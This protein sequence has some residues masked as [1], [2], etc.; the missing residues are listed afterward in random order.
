MNPAPAPT[1]GLAELYRHVWRHAQGVRARWVGAA[2]LLV[3]SQL[4]K[5][6][7]PWMAAQ[8]INTIQQGGAQALQQ[9]AWWIGGIFGVYVLSWSTHGPGRVLER[10]VGV[11]VRQSLSNDLFHRLSHAPLAWHDRH[12]SGELQHRVA[13]ASHA[14]GDFAQ[15][16]YIYLQNA[17]NLFGPLVALATLSTLTGVHAMIGYLV[18]ALVIWRFDLRLT[19]L[20]AQENHADRRYA[21]TLL[22]FLSNISTLMSQRF[23]AHAQRLLGRRLQA[24]FAPLQRNIL[25]TEFKWC[26]VDLLSVALTWSLV[27]AY[28]WHT[29]DAGGTL[30]LGSVFMVYEYAN[31]A[32]G[33]IGAMAAN[34]QNLARIRTDY[35]SCDVIREAPRAPH[36]AGMPLDDW[37]RLDVVDLRYTR[38]DGGGLSGITFQLERGDRVAIVGPSGAGKSTL[39]R[40]LA[41]LYE[42]THGH[43][44]V[45]GVAPLGMRHLGRVTTLIPQEAEVFE[46]TMKENIA[47]DQDVPDALL[48][49]V[50]R[51]SALDDVL[52]GQ[53]LRWE[54]PVVERGAN[55][56][57]GQRQRLCLA[58]GVLAA[59]HSAVVLLDEPTSALDPLTENQVLSQ[60]MAAFPDACVM[61]S[62]HRMSLL[63]H[64][65]KVLLVAE[66]RVVDMGPIAEVRARQALFRELLEHTPTSTGQSV[67]CSEAMA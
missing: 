2:S 46:A 52:A 30:L 58:R 8:A 29:R 53:P 64:F 31:R 23:Q 22:D 62:L 55:L 26:A 20:V 42:P 45:D 41:G 43:I 4:I 34:F 12:H 18:V 15:N 36:E 39:L 60:I 10:S 7:A 32:G 13:Q 44:E 37:Q 16:Q 25:I 67:V 3:L 17:V 11:K 59:R 50:A 19:A 1:L 6:L 66:G 63:T 49:E 48:E 47:F 35:T 14:L 65:N 56:S 9:A 38:P 61:A 5:L 54:T 24:V 40:V 33:V 28:A 57:G 21:A 51:I 27:V